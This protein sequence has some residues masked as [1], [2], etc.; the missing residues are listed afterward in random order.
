MLQN[1]N[2]STKKVIILHIIYNIND[3]KNLKSC[4]HEKKVVTLQDKITI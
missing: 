2:F 3:K 1:Y 4:I